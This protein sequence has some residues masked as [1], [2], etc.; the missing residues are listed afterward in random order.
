V[1]TVKNEGDWMIAWNRTICA[2]GFAFPHGFDKLLS[3]GEYIIFLFTAMNLS[4]HSH[5][6]AFDKAVRRRVGSVR[7]VEL[8]DHKQFSDLKITHI[9]SIGDY[10]GPALM[11][12]IPKIRETSLGSEMSLVTSG[13]TTGALKRKRIVSDTMS[14]TCVE[15]LGTKEESAINKQSEGMIKCQSISRALFDQGS[16]TK[17]ST[18]LPVRGNPQYAIYTLVIASGHGHCTYSVDNTFL[19]ESWSPLCK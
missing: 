1:P 10:L 9:N 19:L 7:N 6:I 11:R 17:T 15:S 3:Y 2:T 8:W 5:I 14:A 13:T 12:N 4:F 16:S 18:A